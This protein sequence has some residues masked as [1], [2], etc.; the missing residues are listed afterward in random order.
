ML[1][2]TA[3]PINSSL[4]QKLSFNLLRDIIPVAAIAIVPNVLEVNPD[5]PIKSVPEL[6]GYAKTNPGKEFAH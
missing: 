2:S 3:N 4:Y 6:I 1:L 5:L